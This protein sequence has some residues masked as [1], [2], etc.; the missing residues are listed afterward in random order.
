MLEAKNINIYAK[1]F[2]QYIEEKKVN[3]EKDLFEKINEIINI[4]ENKEKNKKNSLIIDFLKSSNVEF[5]KKIA[6]ISEICDNEFFLNYLLIINKIGNFSQLDEILVSIIKQYNLSKNIIKANVYSVIE[7]DQ[8]QVKKIKTLILEKT[9]LSAE[10][11]NLIR[12]D[13]IG[14]LIIK[15][16]S[17][18]LDLSIKTLL[19]NMTAKLFFCN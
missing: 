6:L 15:L 13:L 1:K 5:S 10:I 4:F 12:K 14:G 17:L 9:G 7:L 11:E 8:K 19:E 3:F 16:D 18:M 2:L